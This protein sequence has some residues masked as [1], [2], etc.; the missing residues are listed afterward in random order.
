MRKLL[1]L[2][3]LVIV[4]SG[5]G[6]AGQAPVFT[7][8]GIIPILDAY[9]EALRQLAGIPGMSAA[10]V[11]DG[12][13]LWEK[14]YG[15]QNMTSR[16]RTT[17]DTPYMVGEL[18]GTLAAVLVLQC[19][20]QG[21]LEL[22]RPLGE[23]GIDIPEPGATL[24]QLLSHTIA[25]GDTEADPFVYNPGRYGQ[26]TAAMERCAPQ[27]Y[28]KSISHR[29]LNRLAMKDSVP[30]TDLENPQLPMPEGLY[31][32]QELVRYRQ[33]L[34][35]QAVGYRID[36]RGR[37]DPTEVPPAP[38]SANGGLVSTVRDL[39][40]LDG[41]LDTR[42][43]LLDETLGQAWNPVPGLRGLHARR[44][45]NL[46]IVDARCRGDLALRS[47][48]ATSGLR[49][50]FVRSAVRLHRPALRRGAGVSGP[51]ARRS[52]S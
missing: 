20:E 21:H 46:A 16:I 42:L 26:L 29:I 45:R 3:S 37:M 30:G 2:A 49:V 23:Y 28:R 35:R 31:E 19:V 47:A 40:R 43:L 32:P 33:V 6:A 27:P 38:M 13:V 41:A 24:R 25:P 1:S 4:L 39:A 44:G 34:A 50:G 17:P 8:Y 52:G 5:A 12:A 7:P 22:D 15:F 18:S 48:H 51:S 10:L 36:L 11:R 9:L 14:G